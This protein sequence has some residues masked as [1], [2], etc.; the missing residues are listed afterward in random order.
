M[1]LT[2]L[3]EGHWKL[4]PDKAPY[5]DPKSKAKGKAKRHTILKNPDD[6]ERFLGA[7]QP[8]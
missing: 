2:Y 8:K 7:M 4:G 6:R 1:K 3:Y 5:I